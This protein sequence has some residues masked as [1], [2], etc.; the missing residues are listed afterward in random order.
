MKGT[1]RRLT[2]VMITLTM[3]LSVVPAFAASDNGAGSMETKFNYVALGDASAQ[4][5]G[6]T[7]DEEIPFTKVVEGTYPALIRD[8]VKKNG[9]NVKLDNLAIGG[10]RIEEVR[11]LLDDNYKGDAYLKSKFTLDS[12]KDLYRNSIKNADLITIALGNVNFGSALL[13]MA[14]DPEKNCDDPEIK[15]LADADAEGI[16]ASLRAALNNEAK[17]INSTVRQAAS[18]AGY[19]IDT[20]INQYA[21]TYV[22]AVAYVYYSFCKS[23]DEA[24]RLIKEINPNAD[25]LAIELRNMADD[26]SVNAVGANVEAGKLYNNELIA[27]ANAHIKSIAGLY[28][29]IDISN[30]ERFLE[31]IAAYDGNPQNITQNFKNYC[32]LFEDDLLLKS[33]VEAELKSVT[34]SKRAN[35]LNAAYHTVAS[36]LKDVANIK[37]A[38]VE[39]S[40][41]MYLKDNKEKLSTIGKDILDGLKN[42]SVTF[43][44]GNINSKDFIS[45]NSLKLFISGTNGDGGELYSSDS[46]LRIVGRIIMAVGIRAQMGNGFFQ[47]PS[48]KGHEQIAEAIKAKYA[49]KYIHY[50]VADATCEYPGVTKEF[51][52]NVIGGKCYSD[53]A[54]TTEVN[55]N[56][57]LTPSTG[58][59]FGEVTVI[60]APQVGIEGKGQETCTKTGCGHTEEVAI[61]ALNPAGTKLS[62]LKAGR[63][64]ITIYWKKPS[65]ANL[66][67]ITGYQIR[68]SLKSSMKSAKTVLIKKNKTTSTTVKKL[69]AKKKYYVQ[70]RTYK[71]SGGQ[72]YYSS[73]S[74]KKS[75]KTK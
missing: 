51:W 45:N 65:A 35:G 42:K 15:A 11:Y 22:A 44:K 10:M 73:W 56:D 54:Y 53:A 57:C 28:G 2:A 71:L 52:Q 38:S 3:L 66:K 39:L 18:A 24:V 59:E 48:A 62:K 32:D 41:L 26:L 29:T 14:G 43:A 17:K 63:K 7:E 1:F 23:Y 72:K 60:E 6:M 13:F 50:E 68:Y 16:K 69:K 25:I 70:V 19:D 67:N 36:A 4:G 31:E 9:F 49:D 33:A 34:A 12:F 8:A 75:V 47:Q 55:K 40:N 58:H 5:Y 21:D 37:S 46:K 20:L 74:G 61:K 64:K 27:K 30:T